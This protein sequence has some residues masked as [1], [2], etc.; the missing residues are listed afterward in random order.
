ME[1]SKG[2]T[3]EEHDSDVFFIMCTILQATAAAT[4]DETK[5]TVAVMRAEE[6]TE[7][8]TTTAATDTLISVAAKTFVAVSIHIPFHVFVTLSCFHSAFITT[9]TRHRSTSLLLIR[10]FMKAAWT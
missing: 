10:Y 1:R 6:A 4:A 8:A 3:S 7:T 2:K 5:P 9:T